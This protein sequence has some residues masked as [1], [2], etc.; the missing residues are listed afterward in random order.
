MDN[1]QFIET[2]VQKDINVKALMLDS[3]E[4]TM[5]LISVAD[6]MTQAFRQNGKI[7]IAGNGG[8]AADAQ[9]FAAE[10]TSVLTQ[11]VK[12]PGLPAIA[13]T[14]NTSHMT[15]SANDFG[16]NGVFARSV[17]ALAQEGDIFIGISTSGN[18][19]NILSAFKEASKKG[20]TNIGLISDRKCEMRDAADLTIR[21]PSSVT[22]H[23]QE[24]H[25][26]TYHLLCALVERN[27][28][29]RDPTKML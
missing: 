12:R 19:K 17:Q 10:L 15:A 3:D 6:K 29:F 1:K 11:D 20:A 13:L 24:A 2:Y 26:M 4:Y 23:I 8:S 16:F 9:H 27:L 14:T 5:D 25:V 21:I 7:L 22:A 18:S 28:G